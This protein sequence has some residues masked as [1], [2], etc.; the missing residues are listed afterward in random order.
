MEYDASDT[1]DK[2]RYK[3]L[4]DSSKLDNG[5]E[6]YIQ[7]IPDK[8][9]NVLMLRDTGIGMIKTELVKN[10]GTIAHLGTKDFI[11]ALQSGADIS[12]IGQFGVGFYSAYL[13]AD[14]VQEAEKDEVNDKEKIKMLETEVL[15]NTK[16]IWKRNSDN[17]NHEEYAAFYNILIMDDCE[18]LISKY[19][20]FIKGI[21]DSED[22][23]LNI[24]REMLQHNKIF[25]V[26]RK[27]IVK[28][29]IELFSEIA[30]DKE[31]FAKFY[32]TFAKNI[33][34]GIYEDSQNW[35]KLAEFLRY[36]STK[37]TDELTSLNDYIAHMPEK[38]KNIYYISGENHQ[39]VLFMTDPIDEYSILQLKEY[40]GKKLVCITK[41]GVEI[42][43]DEEEKKLPQALRDSSIESYMSSKMVLEINS[44]HSI[45]KSL[46]TKF[47]ADKND[48]IVKDIIWLLFETLLVHS[49]FSLKEPSMLASRIFKIIQLGLDNGY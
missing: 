48:K 25:K 37:S 49:G 15:N 2:I 22:L 5:H 33:K 26:I 1:L 43:E 6:L 24:S 7:I 10:L 36:Y 40:E 28:K 13:V 14:H 47:E 31:D 42:D 30:E 41:K 32:Y 3:L 8:E 11:K 35:Y 44:H 29:F 39:A 12:I 23:P 4:T 19:L 27:N 20:N 17:I 38:Q 34:L 16:P 21:V 45:I 46:K 18:D 9:N